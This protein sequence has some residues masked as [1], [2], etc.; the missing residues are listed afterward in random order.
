MTQEGHRVVL[1]ARS[2][3]RA[4][5]MAALAAR[6]GG[7]VVGDLSRADETRAIADQLNARPPYAHRADQAP[8]A[9]FPS[10]SP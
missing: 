8:R 5:A 7:V 1:H 9:F 10:T 4:S 2:Q 6:S 3:A